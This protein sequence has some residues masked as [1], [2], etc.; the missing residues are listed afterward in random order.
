MGALKKDELGFIR[1]NGYGRV[2]ARELAKQLGL[3]DGETVFRT[4]REKG[5][6][7]SRPISQNGGDVELHPGDTFS[8]GPSIVKAAG[9]LKKLLNGAEDKPT[10]LRRDFPQEALQR[11]AS[12]LGRA[13]FGAVP[14]PEKCRWGW[15]I[16]LKGMTLPGGIRTDALILLPANYP[17][18]SPIGFYIR[19][20]S[21]LG[22]LDT[23]HLY[24]QRT[25]HDAVDLSG[26]GW[27]WFCGIVQNWKPGRH[28]L[29]TYMSLILA[30]FNEKEWK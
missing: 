16:R 30:F 2:A 11:E 25:Y 23:S 5:V 18:S 1:S 7:T 28:N 4:G 14:A 15:K 8:A 22:D 12:G 24:D 6:K 13:G 29:V 20:G 9:F 19:K 17:L 3:E 27:Q 10:P 21:H 26:E